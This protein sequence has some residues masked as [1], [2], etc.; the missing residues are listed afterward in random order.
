MLRAHN[1]HTDGIGRDPNFPLISAEVEV[2]QGLPGQGPLGL[3][4]GA[5][6]PFKDVNNSGYSTIDNEIC[7]GE[8]EIFHLL[9]ILSAEISGGGLR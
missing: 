1:E 2:D 6:D 7:S 9:D 4:Q 5:E 3:L 8:G